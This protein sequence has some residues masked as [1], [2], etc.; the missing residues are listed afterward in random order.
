MHLRV[1]PVPAVIRPHPI[2]R[3][4]LKS[5]YWR[6]FIA[7]AWYFTILCAVERFIDSRDDSLPARGD[8][9]ILTA[10]GY[11]PDFFAAGGHPSRL[12][13]ACRRVSGRS[14]LADGGVITG[15]TGDNCR[16]YDVKLAPAASGFCRHQW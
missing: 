4:L 5:H 11:A 1:V 15:I 13:P 2:P 3:W 16:Q 9:A 8:Y 14:S 7:N 10:P 6:A 12:S